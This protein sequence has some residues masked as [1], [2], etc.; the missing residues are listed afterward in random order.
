MNLRFISLTQQIYH[1]I[2]TVVG[3]LINLFVVFV[4]YYSRQLHYPRHLFWAAI[5][6][7]N[8][9]SIIQTLLEIVAILHGN[10]VACQIFVFNAGVSYTISLTFLALA[11]LDRYLAIGRYEWYKNKVTNRGAVYLLSFGFIVTYA[12]ITSPFWTGFKDFRNCTINLTH[13]HCVMIYDL[14]LGFLCVILHIM[15][16]LRSRKAARQHQNYLETSIAMRFTPTPSI[17]L[18]VPNGKLLKFFQFSFWLFIFINYI[19]LNFL[20]DQ[21]VEIPLREREPSHIDATGIS[22]P[23]QLDDIAESGDHNGIGDT[24]CLPWFFNRPKLNRLEIIAA[25]NMSINILPVWLCTF[26]VTL[27]AIMIYWCIRLEM[28]CPV[29]YRINPYIRDMFLFH[30]VYTPLMYMLTSS[31]FKRAL[32]HCKRKFKCNYSVRT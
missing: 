23:R 10:R 3:T 18:R 2:L 28:N 7:I 16:F 14:L 15:I 21:R 22:L 4:I 17:N 19:F 20:A 30:N 29:I 24:L 12:T 9:F 11:A 26:P 27:N 6:L 5:S 8:E 31:E 32:I 13:M 25:L 1:S